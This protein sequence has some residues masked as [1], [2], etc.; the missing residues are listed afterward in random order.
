MKNG[1]KLSNFTFEVLLIPA[2][3]GEEAFTNGRRENLVERQV[4]F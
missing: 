3:I 4:I 1:R 2:T